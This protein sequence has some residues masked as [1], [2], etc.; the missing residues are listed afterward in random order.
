[1]ADPE[2]EADRYGQG[3][4]INNMFEMTVGEATLDLSDKEIVELF[5]MLLTRKM[6]RYIKEEF[7]I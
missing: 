2:L 5:Q 6:L 1:M 3:E 7:S 4:V